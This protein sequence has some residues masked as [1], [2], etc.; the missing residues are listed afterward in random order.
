[1]LCSSMRMTT[2]SGK[3]WRTWTKVATAKVLTPFPVLIKLVTLMR[4]AAG[5]AA[6]RLR[7]RSHT[8]TLTMSASWEAALSVAS[9]HYTT[10]NLGISFN[11]GDMTCCVDEINLAKDRLIV[12][13]DA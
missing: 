6:K 4:F 5:N 10:R 2:P 7:S 12:F 9:Y 8:S 1:M 3:R 13:S 11:G